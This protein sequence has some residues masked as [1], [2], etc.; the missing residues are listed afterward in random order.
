[1]KRKNEMMKDH[2]EKTVITTLQF[3]FKLISPN[4]MHGSIVK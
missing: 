3:I 2:M 1:M 4:Y